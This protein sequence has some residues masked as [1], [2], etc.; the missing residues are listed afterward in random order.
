M[1]NKSQKTKD[2]GIGHIPNLLEENHIQRVV[3]NDLY[4]GIQL[5]NPAFDGMLTFPILPKFSEI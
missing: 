4:Y 1:Q 2:A 3:Q 5:A